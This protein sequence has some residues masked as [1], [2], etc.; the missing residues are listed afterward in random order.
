MGSKTAE[1]GCLESV[2]VTVVKLVYGVAFD[3]VLAVL[4]HSA[5]PVLSIWQAFVSL[6]VVG[7]LMGW[8]AGLAKYESK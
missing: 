6:L 1:T 2:I 3:A 8:A 7:L 5:F 4:V